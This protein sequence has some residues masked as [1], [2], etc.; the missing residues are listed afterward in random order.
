MSNNL[1]QFYQQDCLDLARSIVIKNSAFAESMNEIDNQSPLYLQRGKQV[2]KNNPKSWRY[3]MHLAGDYHELDEIMK[4]RSL[5]TLQEIDFTKENL[6]NHRA[7]YRGYLLRGEFHKSLIDKYPKQTDLIYGILNPVP[8]E[9]S[10]AANDYDI[11]FIDDTLIEDNEH[12]LLEELQFRIRAN[13]TRWDVGGYKLTDDLYEPTRFALLYM[14]LPLMIMAIRQKYVKTIYTHSFHIWQYLSAHRSL[15][16]FSRFLTKEQTLWLYRNIQW[17]M[18]NP[19]KV[20]TFEALMENI[21]T[22]RAIPLFKYILRTD[23]SDILNYNPKIRADRIQLN[24]PDTDFKSALDTIQIDRLMN[25]EI[26]TAID[27]NTND[28]VLYETVQAEKG[29]KWNKHTNL[30]TKVLE[31][32]LEDNSTSSPFPMANILINEWFYSSYLNRYIPVIS[33]TNPFTAELMAMTPKEA[34]VLFTYAWAEWNSHAQDLIPEISA[35]RVLPAN[36]PDWDKLI[37]QSNKDYDLSVYVNYLKTIYP[38]MESMVSTESFYKYC[39][40]VQKFKLACR[41]IWSYEPNLR[42]SGELRRLLS[43][44]E[45]T[46][47]CQLAN[48]PNQTYVDYFRERSWSV[49]D[50]S[51]ENYKNLALSILNKITGADLNVGIRLS[52]IQ[53]A[54]IKI[55]ERL[56]SYSVQYIHSTSGEETNILDPYPIKLHPHSIEE[57]DIKYTYHGNSEIFNKWTV[58]W[59]VDYLGYSPLDTCLPSHT[60]DSQKAGFDNSLKAKDDTHY[61]YML[62][63][64]KVK[65]DYQED[66]DSLSDADSIL[67]MEDGNIYIEDIRNTQVVDNRVNIDL[68]VNAGE[69]QGN[70]SIDELLADAVTSETFGNLQP[71][72]YSDHYSK[73]LID[74]D[75]NIHLKGIW[76]GNIRVLPGEQMRT[77]LDN[78]EVVLNGFKY[79]TERFGVSQV[80]ELEYLPNVLEGFVY[81]TDKRGTTSTI[82]MNELVKQILEG[83]DYPTNPIGTSQSVTLSDL[84]RNKFNGFTLPEDELGRNNLKLSDVVIDAKDHT[85]N[86]SDN[87]TEAKLTITQTE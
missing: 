28:N 58:C 21:L 85:V 12:Y 5:D 7:T 40:Q 19:G 4:V 69:H 2:N 76:Y 64:R 18:D 36:P 80:V 86:M 14:N 62:N 43:R 56:S 42:K 83:F 59:G 20:D 13:L 30:E 77:P 1:F 53:R 34:C 79:P 72:V 81:P 22:K 51:K 3:Y 15:D 27:N 38:T 23:N 48:R 67:W 31:S 54:M 24:L 78:V 29:L 60:Y 8:Y 26:P 25:K 75:G 66:W 49:F 84:V 10:I 11:L 65:I 16:Q 87:F 39:Q 37:K 57:F 70:M 55:M 71:H 33:L 73:G 9:K 46:Q 32:H 17:I 6:I 50:L 47:Y 82:N 61:R 45:M 63:A 35:Y 44:I 41:N 68:I 52:D 74:G